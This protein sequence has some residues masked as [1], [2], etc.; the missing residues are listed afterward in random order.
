MSIFDVFIDGVKSRAGSMHPDKRRDML[1]RLAEA[2]FP[3]DH[4]TPGMVY[5]ATGPWYEEALWEWENERGN[6][7]QEHGE[8]ED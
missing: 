7:E 5:D 3:G 6:W 8:D 4:E 1:R 2:L